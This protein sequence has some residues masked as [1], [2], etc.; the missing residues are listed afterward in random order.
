MKESRREEEDIKEKKSGDV[1]GEGESY[2]R[3]KNGTSC[4]TWR[5]EETHHLLQ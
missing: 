4:V 2:C 5:A 1:E 3:Q